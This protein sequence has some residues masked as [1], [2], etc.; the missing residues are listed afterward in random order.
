MVLNHNVR[1]VKDSVD[2][3]KYGRLLRYVYVNSLFVN[4]FLAKN[5]YAYILDIPPNDR[6]R[7]LFEASVK[8]AV[9]N[10]VGLWDKCSRID[11]RVEKFKTS[12]VR[13]Q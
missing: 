1:L 9:E 3:D 8:K 7:N 5:G 4:D 6:Y 2:K 10:N 11:S 12:L 13:S